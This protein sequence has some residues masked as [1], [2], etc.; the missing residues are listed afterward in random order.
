[1]NQVF[2][3]NL[4]VTFLYWM[5]NSIDKQNCNSHKTIIIIIPTVST[6]INFNRYLLKR[7]NKL[8]EKLLV[9]RFTTY[10]KTRQGVVTIYDSSD[11]YTSWQHVITIYNR[12]VI[13]IHYTCYYISRQVLQYTTSVITIHNKYYNSRHYY[14]SRQH[15]LPL[16]GYIGMC[17]RKGYGFSAVLVINRVLVSVILVINRVWFLHSSL[18][19]GMFFSSKKLLFNHR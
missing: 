15:I 11:Y 5:H 3:L 1:M 9:L 7:L 12:C 6:V 18:E 19:L 16:M 8:F 4:L 10:H 13:T 2:S 17:G 14:I